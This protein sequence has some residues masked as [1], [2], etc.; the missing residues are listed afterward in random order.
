MTMG[1]LTSHSNQVTLGLI[2]A[3][4]LVLK[5][6]GFRSAAPDGATYWTK[7]A[8]KAHLTVCKPLTTSMSGLIRRK[9]PLSVSPSVP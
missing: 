2:G 1:W 6:S 9:W 4:S 8:T 7:Q 5:D 3:S